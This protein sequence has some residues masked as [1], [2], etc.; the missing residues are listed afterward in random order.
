MR[1]G[2]KSVVPVLLSS[3]Q[4]PET[5]T[6]ILHEFKVGMTLRDYYKAHAPVTWEMARTEANRTS[7][8]GFVE[9]EDVIQTMAKLRG[10]YADAML[11]E[12]NE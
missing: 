2:D 8:G 10:E 4:D 7:T 3:S 12:G 9:Q 1:P 5:G 6:K 11:A